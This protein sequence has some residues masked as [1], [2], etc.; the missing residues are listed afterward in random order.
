M[1]FLGVPLTVKE[2]CGVKGCIIWSTYICQI[3]N[4]K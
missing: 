2:S 3:F 4:S 1:P